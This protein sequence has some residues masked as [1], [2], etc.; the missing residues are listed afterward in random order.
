MITEPGEDLVIEHIR[1]F[2][3]FSIDAL[4]KAL[5]DAHMITGAY[6]EVLTD[7]VNDKKRL[8]VIIATLLNTNKRLL[9]VFLMA[10]VSGGLPYA[11][12]LEGIVTS[13]TC[14]HGN[15]SYSDTWLSSSL[16]AK[17]TSPCQ[18]LITL[19]KLL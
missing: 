5:A 3:Q 8:E 2:E 15:H 6:S 14:M 7:A 17:V 13:L 4:H 16:L 1:E 11:D 18:L 12:D 19:D 10:L 9:T